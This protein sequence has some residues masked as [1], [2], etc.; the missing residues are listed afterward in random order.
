MV[1]VTKRSDMSV[2]CV[3]LGPGEKTCCFC[4]ELRKFIPEPKGGSQCSRHHKQRAAH[5]LEGSQFRRPPN[6]ASLCPSRA[7]FQVQPP[8][9]RRPPEAPGASYHP[10]LHRLQEPGPRGLAARRGRVAGQL[11]VSADLCGRAESGGG[12]SALG[13]EEGRTRECGG[14]ALGLL[15]PQPGTGTGWQQAVTP[16]PLRTACGLCPHWT[17]TQET[18]SCVESYRSVMG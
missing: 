9:G 12:A 1:P 7:A 17:R 6:P 8:P 13:G 14:L 11:P 3:G 16:E 5:S 10:A 2:T 18:G 15:V 4:A